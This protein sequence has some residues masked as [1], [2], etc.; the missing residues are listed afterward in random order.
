MCNLAAPNMAEHRGGGGVPCNGGVSGKGGGIT[1]TSFGGSPSHHHQTHLDVPYDVDVCMAS[2]S[3]DDEDQYDEVFHTY[4]NNNSLN[5]Q[6]HRNIRRSSCSN[7]N[8][9]FNK[10]SNN[11]SC[12]KNSNRNSNSHDNK[13]HENNTI[14]NNN[15]NNMN[16]EQPKQCCCINSNNNNYA[17][18]RSDVE[19][20]KSH[21]QKIELILNEDMK[22][23]LELLE[24]KQNT[25]STNT[26]SGG[27]A[28]RK[29]S[30]KNNGHIYSKTD[31]T[32]HTSVFAIEKAGNGG[33][34]L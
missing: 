12:S 31:K 21:L 18:L 27:N 2:T 15:N 32:N 11:N 23:V 28:F 16:N 9:K 25:T 3:L 8:S 19:D 10:N 30:A 1:S 29:N 34:T 4:S 20:L 22:N 17:E 7:A 33:G 14:P 24:T 5:K 6:R 13:C 26:A